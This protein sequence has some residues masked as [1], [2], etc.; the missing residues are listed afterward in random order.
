MK[1]EDII[2][3]LNIDVK[4]SFTEISPKFVRILEQFSP[5]GPGNMR[6]LFL[7]ENVSLVYPPRIVGNNHIVATLKQNGSEKVFDAIGFNLGN[8]ASII[9]KDRNLI[10]IV[11]TIES[12]NKD[13]KSFPQIRM[14]D[15]HVKENI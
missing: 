12:I 9:D 5:F 4:I 2:P 11:Y 3:E 13:G 1:E 6:P 14:K 7:S 15:I 8:Y 10:D